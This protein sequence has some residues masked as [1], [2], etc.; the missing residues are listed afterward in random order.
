MALVMSIVG[1]T[2]IWV[3][4][5]GTP[6]VANILGGLAVAALLIAVAPDDWPA[7]RRAR[8]RPVAI[9]R[10]VGYL[11]V[12]V[13]RANV[14]LTR[15][16]LTPGSGITTG[17][18]AVPLPGCSDALVTLVTNAIAITPGT[19]PVELDR[20]PTTVLYVHV[21]LLGDVEEVRREILHLT[22]LA[23]RAFGSDTA[24]AALDTL[25]TTEAG[26]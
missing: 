3:L 26:S 14:A 18:V 11:L 2:I 5:W 23:Y 8:L 13:V 4:A 16:V 25:D 7:F 24:V 1:L 15:E 19:M 20:D 6:S 22:E 12:E 10:F 17:V 9:A 21:L